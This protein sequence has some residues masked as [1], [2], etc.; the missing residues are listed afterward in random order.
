MHE[1][2][3]EAVSA[4][5]GFRALM[6]ALT[7]PAIFPLINRIG[8]IP[9]YA[10]FAGVAW[11]GYVYVVFVESL[12]V[13]RILMS[14]QPDYL[15]YPRRRPAALARGLQVF[16][17]DEYISGSTG[18]GKS[19]TGGWMGSGIDQADVVFFATLDER[20]NDL[21][22]TVNLRPVP[23]PGLPATSYRDSSRKLAYSAQW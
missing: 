5:Q 12:S 6:C 3:A 18:S 7:I 21:I 23:V 8:L 20:R 16:G 9:V 15:A 17:R 2:S 1:H 4:N 19:W 22:S 10:I 11:I 13:R 14:C